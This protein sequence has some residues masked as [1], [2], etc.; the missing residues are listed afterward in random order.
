MEINMFK[1]LLSVTLLSIVCLFGVEGNKIVNTEIEKV[2]VYTSGAQIQRS[3]SIQVDSKTEKLIIDDLP[4]DIIDS[5]VRAKGNSTGIVKI[6]DVEVD[7]IHI[8]STGQ[9]RLQNYSRK[10]DSLLIEKEILEDKLNVINKKIEFVE[11]VKAE[12]SKDRNKIITSQQIPVQ[13]WTQIL[14]FIE[15][16]LTIN[17]RERRK[18]KLDLKQINKEIATLTSNINSFHPYPKKKKSIIITIKSESNAIID[19]EVSYSI[20]NAG[21]YSVYDIEADSDKENLA[22]SLYGMVNQRTNESW[23]KIDL[24]LSTANP[25]VEMEIPNIDPLYID[26]RE[27]RKMSLLSS[28]VGYIKDNVYSKNKSLKVGFNQVTGI[29]SDSENGQ[30]LVGV[31]VY[32]RG[33][34]IGVATDEQGFYQINGIPNGE[35]AVRAEYIG[36]NSMTVERV[37]LSSQTAAKINFAMTSTTLQLE[38]IA[39]Y[40]TSPIHEQSSTIKK[41]FIS[42]NYSIQG[43]SNIPNDNNYHKMLLN[44]SVL[45]TEFSYKSVPKHSPTVFI[46]AKSI[47]ESGAQL[48]PGGASLFIDNQFVSKEYFEIVSPKD[49]IELV[50]GKSDRAKIERKLVKKFTNTNG[51]FSKTTIDEYE[52]EISVRNLSDSEIEIDIFDQIPVSQNEDIKIDIKMPEDRVFSLDQYGIIK[53][54]PKLSSK[55]LRIFSFGYSIEYP[56]YKIISGL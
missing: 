35:Y 11:S 25:H 6:I 47:N 44:K 50:F 31:N 4:Y 12:T 41:N 22:L 14:G 1:Q 19:L 30:A 26:T 39:V 27:S 5:S 2:T 42:S 13:N 15:N 3:G 32:L 49:T 17:Y 20:E 37:I 52:F 43:K 48:L 10:K 36:Y 21:W 9:I 56:K 7:L 29:V 23:E 24:E 53:W 46:V 33:T 54:K 16:N 34:N 51:L 55:E 28:D 40:A 8:K 45:P 38:E 18:Y